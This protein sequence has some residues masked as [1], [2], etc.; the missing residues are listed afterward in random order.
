MKIKF[1]DELHQKKYD[2]ILKRM[3]YTSPY[4][5]S[6]AYL[7]ALDESCREHIDDMY[8]FE[9][10]V[11]KPS[12]I[13]K[14]WQTSSSVKTTALAFNLFTSWTVWCEDVDFD[15]S[16]CSVDNI[17]CCEYAPFYYEA[18][19][20]R[21]TEYTNEEKYNI[22]EKDS[23]VLDISDVSSLKEE[24]VNVTEGKDS[25]TENINQFIMGGPKYVYGISES[26]YDDFVKT[27]TEKGWQFCVLGERLTVSGKR[28]IISCTE[29]YNLHKQCL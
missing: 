14:A 9:E 28:Y 18:I 8:D 16:S 21:Y 10:M 26:E 3:A 23:F 24:K 15:V 11:I 17:F 25:L 2:E 29:D 22:M 7:I 19:K 27:A 6:L 5:H 4:H 13:N 12:A 1:R 20:L